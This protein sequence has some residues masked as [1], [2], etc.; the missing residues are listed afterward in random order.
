[1]PYQSDYEMRQISIEMARHTTP[2]AAEALLQLSANYDPTPPPARRWRWPDVLL[3]VALLVQVV[4][5]LRFVGAG[6]YASPETDDFCFAYHYFDDGLSG[7][8]AIFYKTAIGR[9][10]PMVLMTIPAMISKATSIDF[11]I[12]YPLVMITFLAGLVA[13]CI[14]AAARLWPG[15]PIAGRLFLGLMLAATISVNAL[16]LRE[17]LYWLPGAACYLVPAGMLAIILL[18][19]LTSALDGHR[20]TTRAT[21]ALGVLCFA[22]ATCNEFTPIWIMASIAASF[23]L[24]RF[25]QFRQHAAL[26]AC[27]A[28]GFLVLLAAPGNLVRMSQYPAGGRFSAAAGSALTYF[29]YD[30]TVLL[31]QPSSIAW[32]LIC[33][34]M[35]VFI[36]PG[37]PIQRWEAFM[38]SAGLAV[39]FLACSFVTCF[40]AY[41]ATGEILALR[42]RNEIEVIVIQLSI[43]SVA[44]ARLATA[45]LPNRRV[46]AIVL[47][48]ALSFSPLYSRA[49][50][51]WRNQHGSF[52]TFWLET[53]QRHA[54]LSLAKATDLAVPARTVRPS[55]LMQEDLTSDPSRLP[56]DCVAAFYGKRSVVVSP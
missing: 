41:Y 50:G 43:A 54:T 1:M 15:L 38:A 12:V 53:M 32:L 45:R 23:G 20:L 22:A 6:L 35:T 14:W 7:T 9:V 56:N 39:L 3:L 52:N 10:V 31:T 55:V 11:F 28:A 27:T 18:H 29:Y 24:R 49:M 26:A 47:C 30:W 13:L 16:S 33:A 37:K 40:I 44:L 46:A 2:D 51:L 25:S 36:F 4:V 5:L 48:V 19:L 17:M 34:A 21:A 8:V 42:A